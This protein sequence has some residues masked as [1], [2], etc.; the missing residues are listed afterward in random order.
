VATSYTLLGLHYGLRA[1][2][3][4]DR[5]GELEAKAEAM[6]KDSLAVNKGLKR[7]DA[8]AHAYRELAKI[9]D[10][11]GTLDQVEATLKDALALHKKLGDETGMA[12]LYASLGN[13]RS[14]R[15]DKAQACAYWRK[16]AL[17]YPDDRGLVNSLNVNKCATQ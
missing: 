14:K 3:D 4:E 13:G 11:R 2:I 8:M 17:A 15:G 16:G 5:R 9:V 10:R 7:E 6:L 1:E 12:R